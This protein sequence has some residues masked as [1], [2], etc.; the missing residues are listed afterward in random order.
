MIESVRRM[1]PV[2]FLHGV[3]LFLLFSDVTL[4][5]AVQDWGAYQNLNLDDED[6]WFLREEEGVSAAR[7]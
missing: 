7:R 3:L 1:V 6:G 4:C 5:V 2:V